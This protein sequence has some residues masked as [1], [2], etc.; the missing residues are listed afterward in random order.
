[1]RFGG[2]WVPSPQPLSRRA[3]RGAFCFTCLRSVSGR[4][5]VL[6]AVKEVLRVD[7]PLQ[8]G[9]T[10]VLLGAVGG[11]HSLGTIA[12]AEVVHIDAAGVGLHRVPEI[13]R[14]GDVRVSVRWIGPDRDDREVVLGVAV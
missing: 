3:G 12:D 13:A 7:L 1:M 8:R 11:P 6:V 14:P 2:A 4:W 9:E 5:D 10:G